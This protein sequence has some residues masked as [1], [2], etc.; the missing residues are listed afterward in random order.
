MMVSE[1]SDWLKNTVP[2]TII[3][4]AEMI[5]PVYQ[6]GKVKSALLQILERILNLLIA[7]KEEAFAAHVGGAVYYTR[8]LVY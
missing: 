4:K 1:C 5:F 7:H 6:G 2:R 8:R 3:L